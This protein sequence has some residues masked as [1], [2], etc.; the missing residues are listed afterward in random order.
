MS[1]QSPGKVYTREYANSDEVERDL[2][3]AGASLDGMPSKVPLPGLDAAR[4]WYLY[5]EVAPFCLN[6]AKACPK[7]TMPKPKKM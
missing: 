7:P 3:Q 1:A 4:Q 6:P 5:D 2:L